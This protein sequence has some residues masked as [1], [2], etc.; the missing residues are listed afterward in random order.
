MKA[1]ISTVSLNKKIYTLGSP[2]CPN[3]RFSSYFKTPNS[4]SFCYSAQVPSG[5]YSQLQG[6]LLHQD[7]KTALLLSS[8]VI[9]GFS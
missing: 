6:R 8:S 9:V 4:V 1:T 7:I 5:H 2:D 3:F